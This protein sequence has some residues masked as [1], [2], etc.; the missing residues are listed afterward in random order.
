[1]TTR[2]RLEDVLRRHFAAEEE[3]LLAGAPPLATAELT[4]RVLAARR[5]A[6]P[7]RRRGAPLAAAAGV[8]LCALAAALARRGAPAPAPAE[9]AWRLPAIPPLLAAA[10][11]SLS[12]APASARALDWSYLDRLVPAPSAGEGSAETSGRAVE[13]GGNRP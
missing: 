11:A 5:S 1:M 13:Q 7:A 10:P 9:E 8:L 3:A 2:D 12:P 4:E 6:R